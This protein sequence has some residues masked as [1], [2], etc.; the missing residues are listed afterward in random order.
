[1]NK[2][3]AGSIAAVAAAIFIGFFRH[4]FSTQQTESPPSTVRVSETTTVVIPEHSLVEATAASTVAAVSPQV[5]VSTAPI[6]SF[7][8]AKNMW[9]F[10]HVALRSNRPGDLLEGFAATHA[11]EDYLYTEGELNKFSSGAKTKVVGERTPERQLAITEL[12]TRCAGFHQA[13]LASTREI[14][15]TLVGRLATAGFQLQSGNAGTNAQLQNLLSS[16]A[17]D[18]V[19]AATVH[20]LAPLQ[21]KL[22]IPDGDPRE[23]ELATAVMLAQCDLGKDCS[24]GSW[25]SLNE[26]ALAGRCNQDARSNWEQGFDAQQIARIGGYRQQV[27]AS[28][29]NR[30]WSSLGLGK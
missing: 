10:A 22:G 3:Q 6:K 29:R 24:V 16:D 18:A 1:M 23:N 17:P 15:D 26:C 14:R 30:D 8:D 5:K 12:S 2:I 13:G 21:T 11:C 27:V 25:D 28:V 7:G 9:D 20:L 4:E 19:G